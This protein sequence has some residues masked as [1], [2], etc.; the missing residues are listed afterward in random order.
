MTEPVKPISQKQSTAAPA[1][2]TQKMQ[3]VKIGG[4][5]FR[6]DQ[7]E[8]DKTSSYT[9][10]GKKMN[11]VFVKPGVQIDFPDQKND[12]KKPSVESMGLSNKWYNQD[13]SNIHIHDVDNAT[14][15]GNPN[16]SDFINLSGK[17]SGNEIIV[18]QKES[19][20]ING[21]MRK[22]YVELGPDTKNNTVH[23]DKQD[24]TQIW[25]NQM[26]LEMNGIEVQSTLGHIEVEGEGKSFQEAQLKDALPENKYKY[27]EK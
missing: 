2:K 23:M 7:I 9:L 4:I 1:G 27:R 6:K 10:N 11:T 25:Y 15:Y 12:D 17:S 8:A 21:N 24:K 5:E 16:K 3:K 19:W 20:Y 13:D 14:I 22:D 18:D 26:G